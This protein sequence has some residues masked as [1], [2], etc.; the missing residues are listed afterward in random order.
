MSTGD[1]LNELQRRVIDLEARMLASPTMRWATIA[2]VAPLTFKLDGIDAVVEG[3]PS[4]TVSGLSLG[5]RVQVV[6]QAGR[7]TIVGRAKGTQNKVLWSGA[8]FMG[9]AQTA[10]LSE[11][12]RDQATGIVLV[13][14]G[15]ANGAAQ[16]Y[17]IVHEFVPKWQVLGSLNGKG[18]QTTI[19]PGNSASAPFQKYVYVVDERILG[20]ALNNTAPQTSH[21]LTA[22]LGV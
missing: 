5:D 20:N 21:V 10:V 13:W 6:L 7:A 22:V 19:W 8:W 16:L 2:S 1:M 17:D 15:Y 3:T 11:R 14:Q 18:V 9:A 4:T 12:V